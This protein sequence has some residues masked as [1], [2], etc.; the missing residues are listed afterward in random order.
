MPFPCGLCFSQ[1]GCWVLRGS[2]VLRAPRG[3][4]WKLPVLSKGRPGTDMCVRFVDSELRAFPDAA[5]GK[6]V[7]IPDILGCGI[8]PLFY[9]INSS[10]IFHDYFKLY[11]LYSIFAF[12]HSCHLIVFWLLFNFLN[13]TWRATGIS[14]PAPNLLL[15]VGMFCDFSNLSLFLRIIFII[16]S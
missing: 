3:R 4:K 9:P 2:W 6:I 14:E 5:L 10:T 7:L 12:Q 1:G 15:F 11:G 13:G 16:F 8:T